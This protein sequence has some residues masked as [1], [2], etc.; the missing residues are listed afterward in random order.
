MNDEATWLGRAVEL[1]LE[2]EAEG[3]LP[4]G[5]V[6]LLD[7][8][9]IA[10]GRNACL[11]PGYDP[12]RHAEVEA[13]RAVPREL[14]PRARDMTCVST[15]EPCVMCMGTL[16]LHGVRRVAFGA[17]DPDGGAGAVLAHLPPFY[18]PHHLAWIGPLDPARCDPL[19]ARAKAR[20]ATLPA[21][22]TG[23]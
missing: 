3:N 16:L 11:V 12:G 15:L 23:G 19:F 10:E 20:F 7:G 6:L 2:T 4:I 1:A 8:R 13:V 22:R 14:W 9:V 18:P 17:R 21:G 5:A